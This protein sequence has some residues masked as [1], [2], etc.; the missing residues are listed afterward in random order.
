[1]IKNPA[2]EDE[3][4]SIGDRIIP[5]HVTTEAV[6]AL[7]ATL[8]FIEICLKMLDKDYEARRLAYITAMKD[9]FKQIHTTMTKPLI[10]KQKVQKLMTEIGGGW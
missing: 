5:K 3:E 6:E 4:S 1:M 10:T 8:N 2:Y 9:M 7:G